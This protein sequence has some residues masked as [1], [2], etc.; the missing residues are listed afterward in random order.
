MSINDP[1]DGDKKN[2]A[3]SPDTGMEKPKIRILW[4]D[5]DEAIPLGNS[6]LLAGEAYEFII[7]K[8]GQELIDKLNSGEKF[9]LVITDNSMPVKGQSN[10]LTG[11]QVLEYIR[12]EGRFKDLP[13]IVFSS[14]HGI[15]EAVESSKG[16]YFSKSASSEEIAEKLRQV[17]ENIHK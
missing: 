14:D 12:T 15:E 10:P 13:V 16:I 7:V 17:T 1:F 3:T 11:I 4:A 6:Y 5:D 9:D 8:S 2:I